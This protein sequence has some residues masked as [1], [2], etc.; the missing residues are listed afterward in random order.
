MYLQVRQPPT[1]V[2]HRGTR[3]QLTKDVGMASNPDPFEEIE[4][5]DDWVKEARAREDPATV[6]ADRYARINA[7]FK[8]QQQEVQADRK[9]AAKRMSGMSVRTRSWL[10]F[11]GVAAVVVLLMLFVL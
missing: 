11:G 6:R 4:F 10:I 5:T 2:Y 9:A 8:R 3:P 1:C 7:N